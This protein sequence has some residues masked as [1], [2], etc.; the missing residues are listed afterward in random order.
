M[1]CGMLIYEHLHP[2]ACHQDREYEHDVRSL[3]SDRPMR[4]SHAP[5]R[6][7]FLGTVQRCQFVLTV[8][9]TD[10]LAVP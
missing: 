5:W 2:F 4:V 7:F 1:G 8:L 3:L 9:L 6:T 10:W